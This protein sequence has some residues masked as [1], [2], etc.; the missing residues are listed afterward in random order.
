MSGGFPFAIEAFS[1]PKAGNRPEEYEDAWAYRTDGAAANARVAIADGATESSFSKL[2]ATLLVESFVRGRTE[3]FEIL[4]HLAGPRRLWR[5]KVG[6]RKLPWYAAEKARRGAHAAFVGLVLDPAGR[7]WRAAAIGDCCLFQLAGVGPGLRLLRAF[8]LTRSKD[9]GSSPF[10]VGSIDRPGD[11]PSPH[12]RL[13]EGSLPH[14]GTL[15]FASDSL[16]AWLLGREEQGEPAWEAASPLGICGAADFEALVAGA[17][18]EGARNDDMTL[19]RLTSL[20]D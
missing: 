5:R 9:F 17:R 4:S 19:V 12:L 15:L 6:G 7:R 14:D 16:S 11:D 18:E 20:P 1:C 3:G 2:W 13:A 8:P 10:L